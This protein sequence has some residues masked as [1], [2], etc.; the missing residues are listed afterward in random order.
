[1][2]SIKILVYV[3]VVGDRTREVSCGS[4]TGSR[5]VDRNWG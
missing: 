5:D 4:T 3:E 1:M 2:I